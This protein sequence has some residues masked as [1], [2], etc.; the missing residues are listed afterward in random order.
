M[1]QKL[2]RQGDAWMLVIDQ[3]MLD[4]LGVDPE[5]SAVEISVQDRSLI[6][7]SVSE[8]AA[9]QA[10]FEAALETVNRKYG[11]VLRKLAE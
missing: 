2:I 6:L 3:P 11:R 5:L 4:V 7:S 1:I 8:D 9:D 10:R